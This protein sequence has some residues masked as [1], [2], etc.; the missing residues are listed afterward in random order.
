MENFKLHRLGPNAISRFIFVKF[1]FIIIMIIIPYIALN[2]PFWHIIIDSLV[3]TFVY[4]NIFIILLVGTH[5]CEEVHY[6]V[7][8]HDGLVPHGWAYHQVVTALDWMPFSRVVN[9]LAGGANTHV[10]HRLF[11][12]LSHVH[13][14]EIT[15]IVKDE[16]ERF[17]IPYRYASFGGMITSHFRHLRAL[18]APDSAQTACA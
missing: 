1:V 17:G 12:N 11:P 10:A 2:R 6:P 7:A 16:A 4:S 5:H 9:F 3:V 14:V 15:K 13:Y 18:G 8:S